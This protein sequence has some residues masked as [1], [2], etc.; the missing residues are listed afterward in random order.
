MRVCVCLLVLLHHTLTNEIALDVGTFA[1]MFCFSNLFL[2]SYVGA[3]GPTR[4]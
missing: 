1:C 4:T 3:M 2:R